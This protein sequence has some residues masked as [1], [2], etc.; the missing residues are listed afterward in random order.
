MYIS[1]DR[2]KLLAQSL[3]NIE[4]NIHHM[5]WVGEHRSDKYQKAQSEYKGWKDALSHIG[6]LGQVNSMRE[7]P[8]NH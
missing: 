6:I 5:R 2:L 4:Y 1:E 3:D 8:E 7:F